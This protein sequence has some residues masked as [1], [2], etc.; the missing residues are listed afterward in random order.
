MHG[1]MK[2][3]KTAGILCV[4]SRIMHASEMISDDAGKIQE[5]PLF[6]LPFGS[7]EWAREDSAIYD[8]DEVPPASSCTKHVSR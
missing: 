7:D 6:Y 8:G 4:Q 3:R 2:Y 1:E 5:S